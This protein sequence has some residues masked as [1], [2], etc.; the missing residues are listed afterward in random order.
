MTPRRYSRRTLLKLGGAAAAVM[1]LD[2]TRW[3]MPGLAA[4][5]IRSEWTFGSGL[6]A[7]GEFTTPPLRPD[8]RF[9]AV[10]LSWLAM[11]PEF[12]GLRFELRTQGR[13]GDWTEWTTLERDGHTLN[14]D[15]PRAFVAPLMRQ[16]IAIQARVHIESGAGL[17][18]FTVGT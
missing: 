18:E 4:E 2:V 11:S 16:G 3:P 14:P 5:A 12:P 13:G 6:P 15:T 9:D 8:T 10:D 7:A 1:L 17:R